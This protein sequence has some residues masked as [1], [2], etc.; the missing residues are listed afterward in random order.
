[1]RGW[2][3]MS[4]WRVCA[5]C[6][7]GLKHHPGICLKKSEYIHGKFRSELSIPSWKS[8]GS[9]PKREC[10]AVTRRSIQRSTSFMLWQ[11]LLSWWLYV[12]RRCTITAELQKAGTNSAGEHANLQKQIKHAL[13]RVHACIK[14]SH[15]DAFVSMRPSPNYCMDV[16]GTW[17]RTLGLL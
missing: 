17:C 4:M 10:D 1:M 16:N 13:L 5:R 8:N 11:Y 12:L 14:H 6:S 15:D 3:A 9:P 2:M 7:P